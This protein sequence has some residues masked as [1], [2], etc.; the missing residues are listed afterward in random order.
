MEVYEL[1][2]EVM[3]V[4]YD[5]VRVPLLM[6]KRGALLGLGAVPLDGE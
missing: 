2:E 6:P 1:E 4:V 5:L 3:V